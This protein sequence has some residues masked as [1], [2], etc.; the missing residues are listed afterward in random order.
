[1][2]DTVV[3]LNAEE[4][5]GVKPV[6]ILLRGNRMQ[7]Q[8]CVERLAER[9]G[10]Q[11]LRDFDDLF[12]HHFWNLADLGRRYE[13][14][15]EYARQVFRK[16]YGHGYKQV[17]SKKRVERDQEH[18]TCSLNLPPRTEPLLLKLKKK[19]MDMVNFSNG[20]FKINNYIIRFYRV[21]LSTDYGQG[22][23]YFRSAFWDDDF[24]F[25]I[26]QSGETFYIV[27]RSEFTFEPGNQRLV[28]YI[29]DTPYS[30]RHNCAGR[31]KRNFEKYREAWGLLEDRFYI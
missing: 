11:I 5:T 24:D 26:V 31:A 30:G 13:F 28:L 25:G 6:S 23:K 9:Y 1:M 4:H 15:R 14:S 22:V 19:Q 7:S 29:R 16:L 27:P 12:V 18:Q 20:R 2:V 8:T 17:R 10:S 21:L 3:F